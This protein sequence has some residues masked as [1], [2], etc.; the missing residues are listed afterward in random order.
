MA[1]V[2]L[3]PLSA[4]QYEAWLPTSVADYAQE[5]VVSGRW[6]AKEA[7]RRSREEFDHLLPQG[8]ATSGH[9]L[10]S[11]A[12]A[13]DRTPVG[14]RWIQVMEKP[15]PHAFIFNIEIFEPFRR[16]GH[17]TEAMTLLEKKAG[18]LGFESIRLHVF[19][20]NSAARPL[21]EKLGYVPTKIQM[22]KRLT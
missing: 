20:H 10:W 15:L 8:L 12:R 11:I 22:L 7:L 3:V 14:I 13:A 1:E 19:G 17:A 4:K 16:H 9:H 2:E 5:H 18:D 6:S 21:Y